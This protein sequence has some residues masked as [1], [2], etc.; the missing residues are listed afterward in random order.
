M[1]AARTP[2]E[3]TLARVLK[4]TLEMDTHVQVGAYIICHYD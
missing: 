1:L 3:T 4:I 2:L